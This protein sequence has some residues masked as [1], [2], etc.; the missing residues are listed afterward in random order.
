MDIFPD[1]CILYQLHPFS[2]LS[3]LARISLSLS[4]HFVKGKKCGKNADQY[5]SE[6]GHFLRSVNFTNTATFWTKTIHLFPLSLRLS[7]H[8]QQ[9]LISSLDRFLC[10]AA[11]SF[12]YFETDRLW[13]AIYLVQLVRLVRVFCNLRCCTWCRDGERYAVVI[14]CNTISLSSYGTWFYLPSL[15]ILVHDL[16][17]LLCYE[18]WTD[19]RKYFYVICCIFGEVWELDVFYPKYL[20]D[21]LCDYSNI[22]IKERFFIYYTKCSKHCNFLNIFKNVINLVLLASHVLVEY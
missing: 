2:S 8:H 14:C 7:L 16:I 17:S 22:F 12:C 15:N 19:K 13:T 20:I 6:Y 4:L 5:N 3:R 11:A 1:F 10:F 9:I 18:H 21:I